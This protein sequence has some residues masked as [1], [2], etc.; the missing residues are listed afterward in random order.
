[1]PVY[2]WSLSKKLFVFICLLL[3]LITV[4]FFYIAKTSLTQFGTYARDVNTSQIKTMS[5]SYLS[6]IADE[7]AKTYDEMFKKIKI[8][9]SLL[10]NQ[11]TGIYHHMDVFSRLPAGQVSDLHQNQQNHIFFSPRQEPVIT[12]YWGGSTISP[13]IQTELNA[14][15]YVK[16][17]LIKSKKLVQESFAT[18][19]ITR[20]GIGCYYTMD[21]NAKNACYNLPFSSEFDLRQGEPVTLFARQPI[22]Q[23]DTQ[24]TRIYKDDIIDG[25]MMTASTPI[26]DQAGQFKGITGID[27]P[28]EHIVRGLTQGSGPAKNDNIVFGFLQNKEGKFIGFPKAFFDLFG[29]D[30]DLDHFKN[31]SDILNY[32][33][34]DSSIPGVQRAAATIRDH[35]Q[36]VIELTI[37]HEKY[38]LAIGCLGSVEWHLVLVAREADMIISV[39]KTG[40]ALKKSLSSIWKKFI[41]FSLLIVVVFVIS[42]FYAVRLFIFP[43]KHFIEATQKIAR[44]DLS[45]TLEMDRADE[46][47]TLAGSFNTMIEK[48]RV[49][50]KREKDHA[51]ELENNIRL[52]TAQLEKSNAELSDIKN[53]L[54]K[55]IAKRTVQLK[56]LNEHLIFTEED[57]RKAIASD[58]HDSV[59]QTLAMSLSRLKSIRESAS[60]TTRKNLLEVQAYLEQAVQEIRSLIY[61]LSPPILDDFDIETALGFLIDETNAKHR[62]EFHYMDRI[63]QSVCLDQSV[64]VTLYRA[65]SELLTNILKHSGSKKGLIDVSRTQETIRIKVEDH[66]CGFD[67]DRLKR[68]DIIGFGLRSLSER[69]ENL[70]GKIQLAST[71]GKG[72]KIVLTAP[73]STGKTNDHDP[74]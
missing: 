37:N 23:F 48:L 4:P 3:V 67:V 41:G 22:P 18:H 6:R 36:G 11:I 5:G 74:C 73:V 29:L 70:G 56:R 10:G 65:V 66:G 25:L 27:I 43:I 8:T 50:E 24:W 64:K 33:L 9:S 71:P 15:S 72:T 14:L 63:E 55:I 47:G 39:N 58:L 7:Q 45:S 32:S 20:S 62:S 49:S 26:Y 68:L 21:D 12:A 60:G 53:E 34:T 17:L 40:I 35:H 2:N 1:M 52:R 59:T 57:E 51:E 44:G 13:D 54:E 38:L 16:P 46:I 31:S 61:Q 30:I 28:V 69:M 42:V 19:I